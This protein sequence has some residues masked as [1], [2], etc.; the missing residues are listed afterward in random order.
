LHRGNVLVNVEHLVPVSLK[1]PE[2]FVQGI[3]HRTHVGRA[4]VDVRAVREKTKRLRD[5]E[6]DGGT[7][8]NGCDDFLAGESG[9]QGQLEFVLF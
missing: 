3:D 8:S 4:E 9:I 5:F 1:F 6:V 7:G 2:K